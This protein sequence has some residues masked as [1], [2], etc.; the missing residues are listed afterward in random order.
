M[1]VNHRSKYIFQVTQQKY[2]LMN[3]EMKIRYF[4]QIGICMVFSWV[5][6]KN[7]LLL[8]FLNSI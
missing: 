5:K 7:T 1:V 3:S 8:H 4:W 6:K 2:A